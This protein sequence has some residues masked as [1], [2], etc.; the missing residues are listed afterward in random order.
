MYT[1]APLYLRG[2][3]QSILI[4]A[5]LIEA[6]TATWAI[7]QHLEGQ[8]LS[9]AVS[10]GGWYWYF[11]PDVDHSQ[12][13]GHPE[14]PYLCSCAEPRTSVAQFSKAAFAV[15][16]KLVWFGHASSNSFSARDF[17]STFRS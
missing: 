8:V 10:G 6:I 15:Q 9:S 7:Q 2:W 12:T 11:G 13:F 3:T 5:H 1:T 4:E 16:S 17:R 14:L